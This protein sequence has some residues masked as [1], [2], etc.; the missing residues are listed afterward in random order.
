MYEGLTADDITISVPKLY[1]GYATGSNLTMS[2]FE[3]HGD[4]ASVA[5]VAH[6]EGGALAMLSGSR[7]DPLGYVLSEGTYFT[8]ETKTA[9]DVV[10]DTFIDAFRRAP[11]MRDRIRLGSGD[12]R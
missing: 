3:A 9:A 12:A 11:R 1:F 7:R 2:V 5:V 6:L 10:H 4:L 8:G